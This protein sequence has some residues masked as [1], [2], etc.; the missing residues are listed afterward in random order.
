MPSNTPIDAFLAKVRQNN[1]LQSKMKYLGEH[2]S[3][4]L[5]EKLAALSAETG[6]PVS[7]EEWQAILSPK[8]GDELSEEFLTGIAG[9]GTVGDWFSG[10]LHSF[11]RFPV[12]SRSVVQ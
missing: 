3:S 7:V 9:G 12:E 6:T 2:H 10:L 11:P 4:D 5:P 8:S 1:D